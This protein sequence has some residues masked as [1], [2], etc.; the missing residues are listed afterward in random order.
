MSHEGGWVFISHSHQDIL[1]VRYI[2][3]K[4]ENRGFQPL[5]FYLKC[6]ND[7]DEIE[8]LIK[9]EIK[10]RKWFIYAD[11][12]ASRIST[13]VKSER[14]FIKECSGKRIFS[15]DLTQELD[16][17]IDQIAQQLSVFLSFSS[18]NRSTVSAVAERLVKEELLVMDGRQIVVGELYQKQIVN[19]INKA[20]RNGFVLLF[21]SKETMLKKYSFVNIEYDLAKKSGGEIIPIMIGHINPTDI[22][23]SNMQ[24]FMEI[25]RYQ[26]VY[27]DVHPTSQQLDN[28]V[29]EIQSR[30]QISSL[31]EV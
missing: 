30:I 29:E 10:A 24:M 6:L 11:S 8:D 23:D 21:I 9:R 18:E 14:D 19:S 4:L 17:Q 1:K 16:E 28:L 2:R 25:Q 20:S 13:W 31:D 15:I 3:N 7:D 22:D 12:P 26:N 27:I 5:M